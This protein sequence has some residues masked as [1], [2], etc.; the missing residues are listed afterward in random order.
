M[1]LYKYFRELV[2]IPSPSKGEGKVSE[3]M[4]EKLTKKGFSY[5]EDSVGNLLFYRSLEGKKTIISGHMD[6]VPPAVYAHLE[7]DEERFFTDGT[8]AL[9]ADDKCALA[10]MIVLAESYTGDDLVIL[11]TVAEEIGLWG[12]SQIDISFF[13]GL[14]ISQAYILDAQKSVGTVIVEAVGKTRM[15][16]SFKGR[17]AHAGFK[18][19]AGINAI[20]AASDFVS[21]IQTG[22]LGPST[23]SNI[24]SFIA[25]GTTNVVPDLAEIVLEVRSDKTPER[26]AIIADY[27]EKAVL[28]ASKHKAEVEFFEEDLYTEYSIDPESEIVQRAMRAIKA[29]GLE[30][31]TSS[32]TGGSDANNLNKLGIKSVVLTSGYFNGHA[33]TDYIDKIELERLYKTARALFN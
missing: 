6:T 25:E 16:I 8:T 19:E 11:L 10:A 24:G 27:K 1:D 21:S 29:I 33:T 7:E 2:S 23:T 26:N 18:P 15:K 4:K 20:V 9:G 14:D 13:T 30:P 22:R 3:Y 17:K 28:A 32:T 12:S 5:R 31:K